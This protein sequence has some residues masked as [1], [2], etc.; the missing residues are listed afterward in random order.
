MAFEL[1]FFLVKA[2]KIF[3]PI[4]EPENPLFINPMCDG[5]Q[6]LGIERAKANGTKKNR[7]SF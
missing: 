2:H 5:T 1:F 4:Y 7:G 3:K 6:L